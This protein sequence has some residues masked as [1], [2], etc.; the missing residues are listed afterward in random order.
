[1]LDKAVHARVVLLVG[2]PY[3]PGRRLAA[4]TFAKIRIE[5]KNAG[6]LVK[7]L[8]HAYYLV[9]HFGRWLHMVAALR[10]WHA[11]RSQ[12]ENPAPA[13]ETYGR[14][15]L[16]PLAANVRRVILV[17]NAAD[18]YLEPNAARQLAKREG[19][20]IKN[21]PGEHD[22]IWANPLPYVALVERKI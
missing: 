7:S 15:S 6:W 17:R 16:L 14:S 22:D 11:A 4:C 18:T 19:W 2:L 13:V 9:A 1:M 20:Q 10:H 21:M 5:R 8:F 3:W 12:Y